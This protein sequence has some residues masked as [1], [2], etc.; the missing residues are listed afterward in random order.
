[1][2][3]LLSLQPNLKFKLYLVAPEERRDMVEHEIKRPTFS[4][5]EEALSEECGFLPFNKLCET[6]EGTRKLHLASSLQPD[7]FEKVA[8]YFAREPDT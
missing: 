8:E 1:M 5:R 7:L 4:L 6:V 3:D 2:L